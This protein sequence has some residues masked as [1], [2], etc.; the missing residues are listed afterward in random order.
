MFLG[1]SSFTF[2]WGI[3]LEAHQTTPSLTETDLVH[4]TVA[5]DLHCLQ[6]G[7]N[8]PLHTFSVQRLT[9]LKTLAA[10][11]HIR[12]ETGARKLTPAHVQR[13]LELAT[14]LDSPLLR[15]VID[16]T[17]YEPDTASVI[18]IIKDFLP[19]L[20][21]RNIT[22]GIEN[23]DRFRARQLAQIMEA[24]GD[25]A[26][27]ICLDCAN[28]LGAGEGLEQVADILTPYTVNLHIK[29]FAIRRLPH[30]MG[31]TVSGMPAGQ[32]MLNLPWLLEKLKN[33]QPSRCQSAVLE[34]WVVPEPQSGD[35]LLKEQQWADSGVS[36][37]KKV[38]NLI[39]Q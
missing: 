17:G 18:D 21:Q 36:Y 39:K 38:F 30:K 28:S 1:I 37:I 31:F 14:F 27:G 13:Y 26:V 22:L 2:G 32:G 25:A 24:V 20:H 19:E 33:C 12:L 16:D 4:R 35:T 34:Q 10:C 6:I 3:G 23:H 15:F 8:L 9:D 11:H 7:D 5:Y 29:D